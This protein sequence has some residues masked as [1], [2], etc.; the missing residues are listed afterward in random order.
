[1]LRGQEWLL[2]WHYL[3]HSGPSDEVMLCIWFWECQKKLSHTLI[4]DWQNEG[5]WWG[6]PE[7]VLHTLSP[8]SHLLS[9]SINTAY[10]TG[11][12]GR[13]C[14]GSGHQVSKAK[15]RKRSGVRPKRRKFKT[16]H[17][18]RFGSPTIHL[19][20]CTHR[21]AL[22]ATI[23]NAG[24]HSSYGSCFHPSISPPKGDMQLLQST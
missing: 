5:Q 17:G 9:S 2:R 14:E 16:A 3:V 8:D 24:S 18:P 6:C 12:G 23:T 19:Q 22:G 21:S 11:W 10:Q 4:F 15:Y 7:R 13:Q 20:P 1:M